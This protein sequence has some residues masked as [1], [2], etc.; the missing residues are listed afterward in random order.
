MH[1]SQQYH[2]FSKSLKNFLLHFNDQPHIT[3]FNSPK[4]KRKRKHIIADDAK[5]YTAILLLLLS[6]KNLYIRIV[7]YKIKNRRQVF[8]CILL[9]F[10]SFTQ[11]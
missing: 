6:N 5:N 2:L 10:V 1:I 8:F 7:S 3:L 9:K 11:N 4:K